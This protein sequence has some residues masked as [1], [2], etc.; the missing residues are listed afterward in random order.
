MEAKRY[1]NKIL[2]FVFCK[3]ILQSERNRLA[4]TQMRESVASRSALEKNARRDYSKRRK[5]R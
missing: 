2:N 5:T 4:Q 3:S 1:W